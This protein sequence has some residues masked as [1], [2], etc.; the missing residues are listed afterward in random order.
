MFFYIK[1]S[2]EINYLV[3]VDARGFFHAA[4]SSPSICASASFP[5]SLGASYTSKR[6]L[7]LST[8]ARRPGLAVAVAAV[9]AA[10][11]A[12]A[13]GVAVSP[14]TTPPRFLTDAPLF[15]PT[16]RPSKTSLQRSSSMSSSA[17]LMIPRLP[18]LRYAR[19]PVGATESPSLL[20][21][22]GPRRLWHCHRL[23]P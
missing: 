6:S 1:K 23:V 14:T 10:A 8:L 13:V 18:S 5:S 7:F 20:W 2:N 3:Y 11:A 16:P 15:Q 4:I 22:V 17:S 12:A 9:T 21:S 19:L